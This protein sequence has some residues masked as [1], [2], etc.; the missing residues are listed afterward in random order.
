[1]EDGL[2]SQGRDAAKSCGKPSVKPSRVPASHISTRPGTGWRVGRDGLLICLGLAEG[3]V[4]GGGLDC[5]GNITWQYSIKSRKI[6]VLSKKAKNFSRLPARR[7]DFIAELSGCSQKLAGTHDL[8]FLAGFTGRTT[9]NGC[10]CKLLAQTR[11]PSR[12]SA[13]FLAP[14]RPLPSPVR[15]PVFW[16]KISKSQDLFLETHKTSAE[17]TCNRPNI[18]EICQKTLLA[19]RPEQFWGFLDQKHWFSLT[20]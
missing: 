12:F 10:S 3:T 2:A 9:R 8:S 11:D 20:K 7:W 19:G 16:S 13:S 5:V 15:P 6:C 14:A 1:V 17:S 4:S 18:I